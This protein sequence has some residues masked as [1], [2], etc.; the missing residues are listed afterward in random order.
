MEQLDYRFSYNSF[1]GKICDPNVISVETNQYRL[2]VSNCSVRVDP[3]NRRKSESS[4]NVVLRF[5]LG[6][7]IS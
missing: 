2:I 4:R 1:L 6:I 3:E 7:A 5:L